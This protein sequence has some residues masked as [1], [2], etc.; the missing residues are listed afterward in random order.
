[1][2]KNTRQTQNL[3]LTLRNALESIPEI[4]VGDDWFAANEFPNQKLD[5]FTLEFWFLDQ[6]YAVSV[7][8]VPPNKYVEVA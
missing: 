8:K 5:D 7:S 1:M 6:R 3:N 4:K 2:D